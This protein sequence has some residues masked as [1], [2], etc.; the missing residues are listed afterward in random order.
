MDKV[1]SLDYVYKL[2]GEFV[3]EYKSKLEKEVIR[4]AKE[5]FKFDFSFVLYDVTTLYFESFKPDELR[6][7]GFSKDGKSVQPQIVVGLMVTDEGFPLSYDIWEGNTSEGYTFLPTLKNFKKLHDV[8]KLTVI[9]DSA[10]AAKVNKDELV[11]EGFDYIIGASLGKLK[12]KELAVVLEKMQSTHG[13]SIRLDNLIVDFSNARKA[14]DL[15]D[16]QKQVDRAAKYVGK[17]SYKSPKLKF[18]KSSKAENILNQNLIEKHKKLAGLKAYTTNLED[19]VSK[20]EIIQ[21]YHTLFRV[22]HA[23]RIAKSDLESRPIYHHKA[24]SIKN[25]ILICYLALTI[26]VYLELK[27][28]LSIL[29]ITKQLKSITDAKLRNISTGEIVYKRSIKNISFKI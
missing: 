6:K 10:M 28:G 3:P 14:K 1:H 21:H 20:E 12:G 7:P 13:Y 15:Q 11:Q 2:L 16:I 23:W 8:K 29:Q 17:G 18:L 9:A 5:E 22:E 19:T 25:H 24:D 4:I 26:S 27:T